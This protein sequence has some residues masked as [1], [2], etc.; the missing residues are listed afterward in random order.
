MRNLRALPALKVEQTLYF[1]LPFAHEEEA[2]PVVSRPGKLSHAQT[3]L[4]EIDMLRYTAQKLFD[5]KWQSDMDKWSCLEA[6]LVHFRNLIEFFGN[7]R[8]RRDDLHI[9]RVNIFWPDSTSRPADAVLQQ[10]H[11]TDLWEKYEVN[12]SQRIS[13]Y[14]HHCTEERVEPKNWEVDNMYGE[15]NDLLSQFEQ[16]LPDKSRRWPVPALAVR[17]VLGPTSAS[18]ASG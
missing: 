8:P 18:T 7:P 17:N 15:V 1:P 14:L 12:T 13:R 6:F 16:L 10:L 4:Y 3:M 2:M 5:G 9:S 11:K